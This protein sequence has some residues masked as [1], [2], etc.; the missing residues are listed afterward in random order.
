MSNKISNFT[1]TTVARTLPT[2][3][4]FS[5][6]LWNDTIREWTT[7]ATTIR[8]QWNDRLVPLTNKLP[9]GDDDP[10]VDAFKFGLSG[11]HIYMKADATATEDQGRLWN[12]T[13][14]RPATIREVVNA[15]R[16]E[17]TTTIEQ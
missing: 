2:R 11:Y 16:S 1:F 5:S 8:T 15:L 14:S 4:A 17:L 13:K 10:A 12:S 7:D 9:N 6:D 3:G